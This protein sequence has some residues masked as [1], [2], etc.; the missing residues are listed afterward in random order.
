[1]MDL[2]PWAGPLAN[3]YWKIRLHRGGSPSRRTLY[4]RLQ[5][6]KDR[7]R[8]QGICPFQLHAVCRVLRTGG[9]SGTAV[10]R[11]ARVMHTPPKD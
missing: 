2:P 9:W 1:M 10:K 7:L 8:E 4:R 5:A 3:A 6:E 11:L